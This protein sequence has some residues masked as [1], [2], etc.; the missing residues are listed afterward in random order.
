M[1]E[2]GRDLPTASK[3]YQVTHP[4]HGAPLLRPSH[5][6]KAPTSTYHQLRGQNFNIALWR[7][8]HKH[9]VHC[10]YFWLK[11]SKQILFIPGMGS[12]SVHFKMLTNFRV[13]RSFSR[14]QGVFEHVAINMYGVEVFFSQINNLHLHLKQLEKEEQTKPNISRRQEIIKIRAEIN[15]IETKKAYKCCKSIIY[16]NKTR[17]EKKNPTLTLIPTSRLFSLSWHISPKKAVYQYCLQTPASHFP[18]THFS[19]SS[20]PI[21]WL[22]GTCTVLGKSLTTPILSNAKVTALSSLYWSQQQCLSKLTSSS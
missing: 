19:R 11:M 18:S 17:R 12:S 16:L 8:E 4:L 13:E 3:G 5:L 9:P 21:T 6:P 22:P 15:E 1:V 20:L 2:A 14:R 7:A 10:R